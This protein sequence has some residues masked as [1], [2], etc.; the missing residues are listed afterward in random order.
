MLGRLEREEAAS[1]QLDERE[2]VLVSSL[3]LGHPTG[4]A[5]WAFVHDLLSS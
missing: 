2:A 4:I 3:D 1:A 5:N